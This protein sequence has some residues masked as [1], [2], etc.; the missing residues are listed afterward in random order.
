M[1]EKS[2]FNNVPLWTVAFSIILG[3]TLTPM[4]RTVGAQEEDEEFM[5]EDIVV[6]ASKRETKLMETPVSVSAFTSERIDTQGIRSIDDIAR[7]TPGV[8]FGRG[9]FRNPVASMMSIRGVWSNAG[10]STTA[11]YLDNTPIQRRRLGAGAAGFNT[12]PLVFDLERVEVLR[13]PQGTLFGSSSLGGTVRYITPRP[14]LT[15]YSVYARSEMGF[16]DSGGPIYEAGVAVGGPIIEDKLGF[17]L[18][19]FYRYDGGYVDR[20]NT[21][22]EP[23]EEA[24]RTLDLDPT[25]PP[26]VFPTRRET[27]YVV[28]E[29][30]NNFERE[31]IRGALLFAPTDDLEILA[32]LYYQQFSHNDSSMYWEHLSDPDDGIYRQSRPMREPGKDRFFLPAL[33]ITWDAGPVRLFSS[34]SYFDRHQGAINEYA[35]FESAMWGGYWEYPLGMFA[36]TTQI[37]S[38]EGLQ[39]EIRLEST[40]TDSR[41]QW[42][43]GMFYQDTDQ[44]S[45]QKVQNTFLPNLFGDSVGVPFEVAFGVGLVD[46][47]YTFN[48]DPIVSEDK[49]LAGFLQVDFDVTE[50]LTLTAGV[51]VTD[52]EFYSEA[53]Y[54]G[55]VVGPPVD[56]TGSAEETPVTPK[57]SLSYQMTETNLIYATAA[58]GFRIGGYNPQIGLPCIPGMI[59]WGYVCT[60][61]NPTGRPITFDM[62]ELWSY[63]LGS[64]NTLWGG[65]AQLNATVFYIDWRDIQTALMAPMCG[66]GF[67]INGGNAEIMGF[68]VEAT[69]MATDQLRLGIAAGYTDGEYTETIYG[70][71]EATVSLLSEGDSLPDAPWKLMLNAQ[72]DFLVLDRKSFIRFDY[73]YES[74]GPDDSAGFNLANRNPVDPPPDPYTWIPRPDIHQLAVRAGTQIGNFNISIFAKNLLNDNPNLGLDDRA[75]SPVPYGDDAHC[76]RGLTVTPRTIGVT[77][78]YHY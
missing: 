20:V 53:S 46:G 10:S 65:R 24:Y 47:R 72:Y 4:P 68:D 78:V 42:V 17:R 76:Y 74:E 56:D 59:E 6:T 48:Q 69:W 73:E 15:D 8:S 77:V 21:D 28:E 52:T 14:G 38:Q 9:D 27:K 25:T 13:G 54:Y 75:F 58:K 62:D 12:Y 44:T 60:P 67:T 19:A 57:F 36:P 49:Q 16:I 23:G 50:Q 71:P 30:A 64:K 2:K 31:V 32:S 29:N 43:L 5:L 45:I 3:F 34:T 39:Q 55:P 7:L 1:R 40:N 63:E 26:T 35:P 41:L 22:P 70:G 51:R 11:I 37:N 66:F 61:E 33:T 18:S